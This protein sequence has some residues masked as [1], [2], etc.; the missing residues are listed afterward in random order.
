MSK[1]KN[2]YIPTGGYWSSPF[3]RWQGS[4]QNEN[5]IILCA[6]T[7]KKAM[8]E[9]QLDP[10]IFDGVFLGYT[11]PQPS[12][13]Y[14]TPW[15]AAMIGAE[16]VSGPIFSQ[17]CAT[18]TTAIG[19]AA[20]AVDQGMYGNILVALADRCSNGPHMVF[21]NPVGPGGQVIHENWL[22]DNFG[23]DPWAK[24]A[25]IH[26]AENVAK[27]AGI[28]REECDAMALRRYQQYTDGLAN[29]RAFQK[30]YMVALD[31]KMGKKTVTV[32]ADEGVFPTTA[33]GLAGLRP[34]LPGGVITFGAQTHPA[35]GN[36][37]FI[38]TTKE[39]AQELSKDKNITVKLLSYGYARAKKGFMAAAV[40]PAAQMAL[41]VAGL[42]VADLKAVK[43]H[44]PF[45][46]NDVY[47]NKMMKIDDKIVNN[48]GS[49][50]VFGHP[51]GPTA[52]RCIAEMI[53][54][55][56]ILGGGYGLFAGC[57]AG[58]TAAALTLLVE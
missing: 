26:T 22:M 1:F 16:G 14:G 54:E 58:D 50:L 51:Q 47:M 42:K 32:E 23:N 12:C 24:N 19:Y 36:A 55:L 11:I 15:L 52:G 37:G 40:V 56:I 57:A 38:V 31:L 20:A 29:D 8:S 4:L 39:K 7:I 13:F 5:A 18:S 27:E 3:C 43:T 17:A 25:M 28:T 49:S 30:R 44:N 10:K 9:R 48:Y 33:E 35:D 53:E 46:V 41:D 2:A 6:N 21:P 34:A 45:A